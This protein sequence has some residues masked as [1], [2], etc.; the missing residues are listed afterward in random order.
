MVYGPRGEYSLLINLEG[1][2]GI[3]ESLNSGRTAVTSD[4]AVRFGQVG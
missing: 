3:D 2:S 1:E 4:G